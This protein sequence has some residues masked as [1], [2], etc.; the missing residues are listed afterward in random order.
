MYRSA[1]TEY[2]QLS[3]SGQFK[4]F[5]A[6]IEQRWATQHHFSMHG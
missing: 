2:A 6:D 1:A 3:Y 4:Q 5:V